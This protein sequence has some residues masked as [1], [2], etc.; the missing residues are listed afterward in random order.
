[1]IESRREVCQR[2]KRIT[3]ESE[4][5]IK[6]LF[7]M[8]CIYTRNSV[9]YQLSAKIIELEGLC[10][11]L[12]KQE[13]LNEK[14]VQPRQRDFTLEELSKY[15]GKDGNP[16]YVAVNGVVYDVTNNAAWAAATHFG[17]TAGK[18][19]TGEFASCHAGQTVLSEL[20]VV[21]KLI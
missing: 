13:N 17:L 6:L 15:T 18:D 16:A 12:I 10:N 9:L 14:Q 21:G 20:T 19:L 7:M 1:M 2:M 8:P 5:D 3:L 11:Q 4:K